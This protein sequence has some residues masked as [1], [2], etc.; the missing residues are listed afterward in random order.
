MPTQTSQISG[1]VQAIVISLEFPP[2]FLFA[3]EVAARV[4]RGE[5]GPMSPM[6]AIYRKSLPVV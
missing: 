2:Q 1:V 4:R 5:Q 6:P 3:S